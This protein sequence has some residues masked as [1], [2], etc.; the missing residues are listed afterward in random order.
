VEERAK[1]GIGAAPA[2][3]GGAGGGMQG[4][5]TGEIVIPESSRIAYSHN[6]PGN[7]K[8]VGQE[9]ATEGDA[10]GDG[11]SF[12]KF[13]SPEAGLDALRAQI[14]KDAGRGLTVREFISKYAPP[15]SNDTETY[16]RQALGSLRAKEDDLLEDLDTYDVMRFVAK[17]ESSTEL[18]SQYDDDGQAAMAEQGAAER[19]A[20]TPMGPPTAAEHAASTKPLSELTS[21]ERKARIAQLKQ[22]LGR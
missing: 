6:N 11:G 7:L 4:V 5:E 22:Q 16:I 10:A 12:A 1:W 17:K 15:K 13:E 20:A 18:P 21:E 19:A 9:G 14:E 8:F 2:A 3:S